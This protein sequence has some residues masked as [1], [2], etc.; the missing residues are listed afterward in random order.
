MTTDRLHSALGAV[1]RDVRR[2]TV[3]VHDRHGRGSGV[4]WADGLVISNAHVVRDAR[5][6]VETAAGRARGRL[7]A[8]DP[9]RDLAA[10]HVDLAGLDTKVCALRDLATL[11]CGELV[12]AVGNPLGLSGAVASGAFQHAA[13]RFVVSDV[14][15][16]PGNSGGPLTDAAGLV[17]GV[18]SMVAGRL[19]YAVASEAVRAFLADGGFAWRAA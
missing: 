7:I 8:R 2:A 13:G 19:A 16:A 18:N 4:V 12:L 6:F 5:P 14:R 15:L 11:R 1:V 9:S 3:H 10:I 17:I